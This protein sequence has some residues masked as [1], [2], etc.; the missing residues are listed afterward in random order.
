MRRWL[1]LILGGAVCAGCWIQPPAQCPNAVP[2]VLACS[3]PHYAQCI[4][5]NSVVVDLCNVG[6]VTCVK[7]CP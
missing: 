4:E 2:V 1:L 7:E 6:R 5:A 3:D